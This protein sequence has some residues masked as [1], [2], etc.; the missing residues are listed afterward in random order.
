MNAQNLPQKKVTAL[1]DRGRKNKLQ[2]K[3]NV[4]GKRKSVN[5][6]GQW[7]GPSSWSGHYIWQLVFMTMMTM[8]ILLGITQHNQS[9]QSTETLLDQAA[10]RKIKMWEA[11]THKYWTY[12]T[13]QPGKQMWLS[14]FLFIEGRLTK[15]R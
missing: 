4:L 6:A 10:N 14:L 11:E 7:E 3:N 8:I 5:G 13:V 9:N 2:G 12:C 1:L 15:Y